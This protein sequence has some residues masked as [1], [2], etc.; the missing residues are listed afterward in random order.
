MYVG[1]CVWERDRGGCVGDVLLRVWIQMFL[2]CVMKE[3]EQ[4]KHL[5]NKTLNYIISMGIYQHHPHLHRHRHR[6]SLQII[7]L[8]SIRIKMK[9]TLIICYKRPGYKIW[10]VCVCVCVETFAFLIIIINFLF[11]RILKQKCSCS[12][13]FCLGFWN[14]DEIGILVCVCVC[15][16]VL[17]YE[18]EKTF[19]FV[20]SLI[21][22]SCWIL[23][24][25]FLRSRGRIKFFSGDVLW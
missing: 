8:R 4:L 5:W 11:H 20:I 12:V 15:Y 18:K 23:E 3:K 2:Y 17:E 21:L 24:Y 9:K 19:N 16:V 1:V 7:M 25:F 6:H 13:T 10:C 14:D 22:S